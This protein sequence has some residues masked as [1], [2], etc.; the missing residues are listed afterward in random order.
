MFCGCRYTLTAH[1]YWELLA[2]WI[3]LH[4]DTDM[5]VE[6]SNDH[7]DLF[8]RRD[9]DFV[10]RKT[11]PALVSYTSI[12]QR[13]VSMVH[14]L[15]LIWRRW[16]DVKTPSSSLC[17]LWAAHAFR[18]GAVRWRRDGCFLSFGYSPEPMSVL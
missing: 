14:T 12:T 10:S 15:T 11:H 2:V 4:T 13:E 7:P 17:H 18:G 9:A 6:D 5:F 16:V 3:E 1:N 8:D